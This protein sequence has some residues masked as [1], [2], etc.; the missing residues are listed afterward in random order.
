M[1]RQLIL[2]KLES[3]R[4]CVR[5]VEEKCPDQQETLFEDWD[6]QDILALNLTRAVQLC[7]DIAAHLIAS[8]D[9]PAPDTMAGTFETMH[10]AGMLPAALTDRMRRAVGFRNVA[11]HNYR[12]IDWRI[13]YTIC[14][15]HM[16]DFKAFAQTVLDIVDD[17]DE[18]TSY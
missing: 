17:S 12:D 14:H 9:L 15:E 5:R 8:S 6:V 11:I 7:V 2:E 10:Q 3:L 4:R 16:S 18:H 13:V 1:D